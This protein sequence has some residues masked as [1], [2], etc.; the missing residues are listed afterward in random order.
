MILL[1]LEKPL[2]NPT[3]LRTFYFLPYGCQTQA[4]K[5]C[6]HGVNTFLSSSTTHRTFYLPYYL[7]IVFHY[8]QVSRTPFDGNREKKLWTQQTLDNQEGCLCSTSSKTLSLLFFFSPQI[9]ISTFLCFCVFFLSKWK[10][11]TQIVAFLY[12]AYKQRQVSISAYPNFLLN[13]DLNQFGT[14][15]WLAKTWS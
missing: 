5:G 4:S 11:V 14:V 15:G 2:K 7:S 9:C 1:L 13:N 10:L 8:C 6:K 3:D 12:V